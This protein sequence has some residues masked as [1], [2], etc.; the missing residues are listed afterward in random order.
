MSTTKIINDF[1]KCLLREKIC[2][3]KFN[4]NNF[5]KKPNNIISL[6]ESIK[7]IN[8]YNEFHE[9]RYNEPLT[10]TE[11]L[12]NPRLKRL[13]KCLNN[14]GNYKQDY[15]HY[16][17][18]EQRL[19]SARKNYNIKTL[20]ILKYSDCVT[21][22]QKRN[23]TRDGIFLKRKNLNTN[24]VNDEVRIRPLTLKLDYEYLEKRGNKKMENYYINNDDEH[25][26]IYNS[27]K[28]KDTLSCFLYHVNNLASYQ[29]E[30]TK[31]SADSTDKKSLQFYNFEILKS[32]QKNKN[33]N[34]KKPKEI[35]RT[36]VDISNIFLIQKPLITSIR[37]KILKNLKKRFK[38]PIRNILK[39]HI[40]YNYQENEKN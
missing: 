23:K 33:T 13:S 21:I 31:S 9:S 20:D 27:N 1:N 39:S 5:R 17:Y 32:L 3:Y 38:R 22:T 7:T 28:F 35:K 15:N 26:N 8:S 25:L 10:T 11:A 36:E 24:L 40:F 30:N 34:T 18:C 16:K 19:N 4:P 12:N 29:R 14:I 2:D 37:G 6:F